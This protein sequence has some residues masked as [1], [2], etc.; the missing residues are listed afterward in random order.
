ML[1][2]AGRPCVLVVRL[3]YKG[4]NYDFAVPL[5]SNINKSAPRSEYFPLPPRPATRPGNRHGIHYIKMFPINRKKAIYFRTH[6]NSH[7]TLIKSII[8][9][10]EKQIVRECQEYLNL[11]S[12]GNRPM[13]STDI[14]LLLSVI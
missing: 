11:V 5:R 13:Y 10:N 2:K 12:S 7:A 1:H 3:K 6:G 9:K 14:D 8:D 4:R